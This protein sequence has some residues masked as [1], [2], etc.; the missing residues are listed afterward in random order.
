MT[1]N[2]LIAEF[3]RPINNYDHLYEVSSIGRIR[4]KRR[5]HICKPFRRKYLAVGLSKK[6]SVKIHSVHRLVAIAFIPNPENKPTVNHVNGD[7]FNNHINN[8]EWATFS[9][10]Q[11]HSIK[12]G[13][14]NPMLNPMKGKYGFNHNR[15]KAVSSIDS[16]GNVLGVYGSTREAARA[17]GLTQTSVSKCCRDQLKQTKGFQF[18]WYN[19]QPK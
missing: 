19:A 10:Q 7:K 15:S 14:R 6:G 9:E 12:A 13:L 1:D 17:L 2:E 3:W 8:L 4:N 18:K 5:G 11:K 16:N